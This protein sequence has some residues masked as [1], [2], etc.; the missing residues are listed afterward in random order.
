MCLLAGSLSLWTDVWQ[1]KNSVHI[2]QTL[3]AIHDAQNI[4]QKLLIPVTALLIN[5]TYLCSWLD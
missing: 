1:V 2:P 4:T 5:H 3:A